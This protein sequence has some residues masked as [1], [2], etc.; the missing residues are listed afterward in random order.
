MWNLG[1]T[2]VRALHAFPVTRLRKDAIGL[3]KMQ[4]RRFI[5]MLSR[6]ELFS[7]EERL[8]TPALFSLESRMLK[9]VMGVIYKIMKGIH[10]VDSWKPLSILEVDKA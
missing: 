10:R 5:R 2:S 8:E 1:L 4:K 9:G 7:Y 6:M 3:E